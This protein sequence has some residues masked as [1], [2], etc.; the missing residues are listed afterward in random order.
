MSEPV[1]LARSARE[2]LAAALNALQSNAAVPPELEDLAEP[3]AEAMGIL[4]RIERSSGQDLNGRDLVLSRVR[5]AL[6]KLQALTT[7][8][9]VV[10]VVMEA[11]ALSLSKVHALTRVSARSA[12]QTA[13]AA[14]PAPPPAP[15]PA[16]APAPPPA[17][18][19]AAAPAPAPVVPQHAPAPAPVVP[20]RVIEPAPAP[21]HAAPPAAAAPA[22]VVPLRPVEPA[23]APGPV[24]P[25]RLVEPA[26]PAPR[27]VAEPSAPAPRRVA[28]PTA[29]PQPQAAPKAAVPT[30]DV[31]LG[32]NSASNF[33]KGLSGNDVIEH[34]GI[35]VATYK[36][37]RIGS[38]VRLRIHL[39]GNYDFHASATVQW[40]REPGG[41][42][43][44][45]EPGFGARFTQISP[46]ARQLVYRFTRN[47]EP[48]F[49]DDL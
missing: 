38:T 20:Q 5:D 3:I 9:P 44:S 18:A 11:V 16:A 12:A 41:S 39:P 15:A 8:H 48:L 25:Q 6:N 26:P 34:G 28:E 40:I 21:R 1:Q 22:P 33:Y 45:M 49:Y 42:D 47:R 43:D 36:I 24:V 32:T 13:P 31:E 7:D 37:P 46:E 4:H 27:P 19:P 35:F 23:A 17:P 30:I 29:P 10:D 2:Q 14:A